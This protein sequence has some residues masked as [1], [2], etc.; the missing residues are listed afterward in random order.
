VVAAGVVVTMFDT[1]TINANVNR[2]A[3]DAAMT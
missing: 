1:A 2:V 3:T